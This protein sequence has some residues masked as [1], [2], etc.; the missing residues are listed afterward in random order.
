MR[1]QLKGWRFG[2][3]IGS[4][5]GLVG[6]QCYFT[7][8]SPMLNPEPYKKIREQIAEKHPEIQ[9]DLEK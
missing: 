7:M 8:I 5:I 1:R 4:F 3:F 9:L 6:L 2:I